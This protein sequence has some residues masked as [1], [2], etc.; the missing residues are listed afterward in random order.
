MTQSEW[1]Y[2]KE[3]E[4]TTATLYYGAKVPVAYLIHVMVGAIEALEKLDE[5][6]KAIFY[7]RPISVPPI[8]Y[9]SHTCDNLPA[10]ISNEST[11]EADQRAV[12]LIHGI[13]GKATEGGELLQALLETIGNGQPLNYLN[14]EEEIGDSL[15][16]DALL[17]RTLGRTFEEVQRSNIAKLRKRYPGKFSEEAANNRN[18]DAELSALE[19]EQKTLTDN[20]LEL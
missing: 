8:I 10:W 16:Y 19:G 9:G 20:T 4:R 6:K 18:L 5:I 15:W 17:L 13:L 7:N 2:M 14:V 3:A 12:D 11:A 1:D